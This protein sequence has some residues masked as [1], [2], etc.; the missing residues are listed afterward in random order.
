MVNV[1]HVP[2]PSKVS[3]TNPLWYTFE[4]ERDVITSSIVPGNDNLLNLRPQQRIKERLGEHAG[5]KVGSL[6]P[7][8]RNCSRINRECNQWGFCKKSGWPAKAMG[9]R[10]SHICMQ[11]SFL[12]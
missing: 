4:S 11:V 1:E 10:P 12:H 8:S 3:P 5:F 9:W 2:G 6:S 7:S